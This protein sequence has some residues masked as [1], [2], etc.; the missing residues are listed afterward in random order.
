M[1]CVA[2]AIFNEFGEPIGGV[3]VSGPTVR[4]TPERLAEIGPLVREAA[5]E[6]T[7][8]IGGLST[9]SS[10]GRAGASGSL[11]DVTAARSP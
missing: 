7:R 1:R 10:Q 9:P 3:S 11:F 2:A 6:I 4:V 5:A 8:M